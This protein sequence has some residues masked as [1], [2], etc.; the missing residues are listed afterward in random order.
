M[1]FRKRHRRVLTIS[2]LAFGFGWMLA[3]VQ[4]HAQAATSDPAVQRGTA[5]FQ[6]NCAACHGTHATGGI[7]PNLIHSGIVRYPEK[8]GDLV[9]QVIQSGRPDHGM[10]AFTTLT[11]QNISDIVAFLHARVA[12]SDQSDTEAGGGDYPLAQLLS[13]NTDA[14]KRYFY[15]AGKCA[16]C[17]STTGDLK[18]IAGRHTAEELEE[19]FLFP[20]GPESTATVSLRSGKQVQGRLVHQDP[21]YVSVVDTDGWYRSW[22]AT[23][24]KV[25][26]KNPLAGHL[27]L[28]Q[29][30]SDK[31]IHDV[32]AYLE[33][34]K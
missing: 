16:T 2:L 11:S 17:H 1:H 20:A 29:T 19:I 7:G 9:N 6:Q 25:Q 14:G 8:Y 5:L 23:D 18:G 10:P 26:V 27:D 28:L 31:E 32:F 21:F 22:P 33:T 34:L 12:A 4:A 24:V 15:G 13:G 3:P 30:I